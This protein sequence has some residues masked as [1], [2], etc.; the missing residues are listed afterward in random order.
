MSLHKHLILNLKVANIQTINA[1][2][3]VSHQIS[4]DVLRLDK[5]HPIVS[6]N[7]WFKLKYY[8]L[9]AKAQNKTVATLGGAWSN[10]IV[11]TAF[12]CLKAGLP[13][14][15]FIRGE[16]P[17]VYS[18]TLKQAEQFGMNLQFLT[19][20][21]YA[22]K[23][24]DL[25]M[26]GVISRAID[27]E[28]IYWIGEGGYGIHGAKGAGDIAL[29]YDLKNFT[30]IIAGVGSGTM[31]AGLINSATSKQKIIGISSMKG[32]A[33]LEQQVKNLI[34]E[35]IKCNNFSILHDYHFG[36]FGKHPGELLDFINGVYTDHQLPLDIVYT[37]KVFF[38]IRDLVNKNYF[39]PHSRLLMIHSGGLQGNAG[40]KEKILAF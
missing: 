9:E 22:E 6:G 5:I 17:A 40:V 14:V 32:N 16:K 23:V 24:A 36:G 20:T 39:K 33:E 35:K 7:K 29:E 3:L 1:P 19:R 18:E 27:K 11:A 21:A 4:L 26:K 13:C 15:G 2:W 28:N 37:G 31:L 38:A 34:M 10:H 30:H 25:K 12:C 8:L